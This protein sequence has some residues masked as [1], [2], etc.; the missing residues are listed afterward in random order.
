V[1]AVT[2]QNASAS[3]E[4]ASTAEELAS[5]AESLQ[6]IVAAFQIGAEHVGSE[7]AALVADPAS[8]T[9]RQTWPVASKHYGAANKRARRDVSTYTPRANAVVPGARGDERDFVRF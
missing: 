2:Q 5:Q 4:L 6:Q 8:L 9:Q 1:D 7:H 3:E